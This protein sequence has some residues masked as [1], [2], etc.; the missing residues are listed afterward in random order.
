MVDHRRGG[1]GRVEVSL[2]GGSWGFAEVHLDAGWGSRVV[3]G[4]GR[5]WSANLLKTSTKPVRCY[6]TKSN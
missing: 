6:G 4:G 3:E 5:E 1:R 2:L